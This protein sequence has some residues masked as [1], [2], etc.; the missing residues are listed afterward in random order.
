MATE[1]FYKRDGEKHG[2]FS[3]QQLRGMATSG[4]LLPSDLIWK[5]GMSDWRRAG[6]SSQLFTHSASTPPRAVPG[7]DKPPAEARPAASRFAATAKSAAQ[8]TQ[9]AAERTKLSTVSLPAAYHALG[10]HCYETRSLIQDFQADFAE[11]DN[12]AK[13]V[14]G[15]SLSASNPTPTSFSER[16]KAVAG[17]GIEYAQRQK[18]VLQQALV[19]KRLGQAAFEKHGDRAGPNS[20]EVVRIR[21]RIAAID[22]TLASMKSAMRG[23]HAP[24]KRVIAVTAGAATLVLLGMVGY[25]LVSGGSKLAPQSD[26][27]TEVAATND[28][29]STPTAGIQDASLLHLLQTQRAK[30]YS[31]KKD[32]RRVVHVIVEPE[33]KMGLDLSWLEQLQS[34]EGVEVDAPRGSVLEKASLQS[35]L[36][37]FLA[38]DVEVSPSVLSTLVDQCPQ[39]V[40]LAFRAPRNATAAAYIDVLEKCPNLRVLGVNCEQ[41]P[42]KAAFCRLRQLEVLE[43]TVRQNSPGISAVILSTVAD[44]PKLK[45]LIVND[46]YLGG[47]KSEPFGF[48]DLKDLP[49]LDTLV[50]GDKGGAASSRENALKSLAELSQ[51]KAIWVKGSGSEQQDTML[52]TLLGAAYKG[53]GFNRG[54]PKAPRYRD[55]LP[56]ANCELGRIGFDESNKIV[57]MPPVVRKQLTHF[58]IG[59]QRGR[60][61]AEILMSQVNAVGISRAKELYEK[62]AQEHIE[63]AREDIRQYPNLPEIYDHARGFLKGFD[64]AYKYE[65][66]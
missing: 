36:S 47:R 30:F 24:N 14:A 44:H 58:Q 33:Q 60:K 19:M 46:L 61:L 43:L 63:K 16:A 8:V 51:V 1:W 22:D 37:V 17:K 21:D 26:S 9:L 53:D 56:A 66:P 32:I 13:V 4:Q 45:C 31:A 50:I 65:K 2:P 34:L 27:N 64:E 52:N 15:Q 3:S 6:D 59:E 10:Q 7:N 29:V 25:G 49:Q 12:L 48:S 57:F 28:P 5:E 11:L 62:T 38:E 42:P 23:P 20:G 35:N 55:F 40:A 39:L 54:S 18:A 41:P